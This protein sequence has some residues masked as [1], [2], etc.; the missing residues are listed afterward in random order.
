MQ[1]TLILLAILVVPGVFPCAVSAVPCRTEIRGNTI[2]MAQTGTTSGVFDRWS[3]AQ[4][5]KILNKG[6]LMAKAALS[7]KTYGHTSSHSA[8]REG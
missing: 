1:K 3:L 5:V 2:V 6:Q 4:S 8:K 7:P